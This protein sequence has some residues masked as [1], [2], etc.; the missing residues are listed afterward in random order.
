MATNLRTIQHPA[1][2]KRRDRLNRELGDQRNWPKNSVAFDDSKYATVA[3]ISIHGVDLEDRDIIGWGLAQCAAATGP[4]ASVD[5][6]YGEGASLEWKRNATDADI[7]KCMQPAKD[8]TKDRAIRVCFVDTLVASSGW[9]P[10]NFSI[11]PDTINTLRAFGLSGL[12]L[13]NLWT[14]DGYWAK[15][16][17]QRFMRCRADGNLEAL[18]VCYQYRSGWDGP[19]S[20]IHFIATS[21][22]STNFCI[23]YPAGARDRLEELIKEDPSV[24]YRPFFLD[25]LAAD[26]SLKRWQIDIGQRRQKLREFEVAYNSDRVE[27][28]AATRDLHEMSLQWLSLGQD[29]MDLKLQ[30]DFLRDA[31]MRY[32][33]KV[34]ANTFIWTVDLIED[35]RD[36]IDVLRSQCDICH[37]WTQVYRE[38]T[39]NRINLVFHLVNQQEMKTSRDIAAT[40]TEVAKATARVARETQ[41]DSA[42]MITIAVVTMVFLP[43]TFICAITSTTFFENAGRD[44]KVSPKL[45]ILIVVSFL[46]TVSILA[47]WKIWR[48]WRLRKLERERK[49]EESKSVGSENS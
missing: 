49:R 29:C 23:N 18:E 33:E 14:E 40:N 10:G 44:V 48:D 9:L 17:N 25:T 5:V 26:D 24:L 20:F 45:W 28:D 16:G 3:T 13:C 19:V 21:S 22:Q 42:S 32:E 35:V 46:L 15:M 27:Y 7:E 37:R 34:R 30:M 12:L 31:Y 8:K 43:G 2:R 41:R 1:L 39:D 11:S 38:R 36:T 4:R 47:V 6:L